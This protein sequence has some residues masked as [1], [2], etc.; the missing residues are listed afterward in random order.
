LKKDS[1]QMTMRRLIYA[2]AAL[3]LSLGGLATAASATVYGNYVDPSGTVSYLNVQDTNG[4]FGEPTVSLNSLDFTPTEYEAQCSA[5]PTG[6]TTADILTLDIQATAGQ[7]INEVEIN[8]G[9]DY[10]L[11]SFDPTGFASVIVTATITIDITEVNGQSVNNIS[12]I[13]QVI[14]DPANNVTVS[15]IA[16]D[17]GVLIGG[18]GAISIQQILADNGATGEATRV[19]ISL[20][21]T[22]R[23]FHDGSGGLAHIRKRDTDFVSLTINGGNPVPEPSTALLMMG[24][25]ALLARRRQSPRS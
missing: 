19:S 5:C 3:L 8:E 13:Q 23:A 15:G 20:D 22:L 14:F 24:G 7:Q 4:L 11:Q 21:N 2:L 6:V 1:N 12:E 18:T 10:S 9:L 25:L 16:I 17:D